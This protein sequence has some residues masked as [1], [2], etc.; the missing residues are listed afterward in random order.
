MSSSEASSSMKELVEKVKKSKKPSSSKKGRSSKKSRSSSKKISKKSPSSEKAESFFSSI[1]KRFNNNR[2]MW[3]G[4]ALLLVVVIWY[5]MK[6]KKKKLN[7]TPENKLENKLENTQKNIQNVQEEIKK[8][9]F[10]RDENDKKNNVVRMKLPEKYMTDDN[11]RPVVL[12]PEVIK[13]IEEHTRRQLMTQKKKMKKVKNDSEDGET[14][15]VKSQD[16]SNTEMEEI[17]T[18]LDMMDNSN[19]IMP[20]NN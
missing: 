5:Y 12:T 13:N 2:M 20:S 19:S 1:I 17:R 6:G 10:E 4:V 14:D 3:G 9:F 16:L 15:N 7:H 18:Q 8:A 11:G